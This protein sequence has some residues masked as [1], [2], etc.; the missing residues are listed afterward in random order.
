MILGGPWPPEP[1][2]F[3]L[4][5][6]Q[7]HCVDRRKSLRLAQEVKLRDNDEAMPEAS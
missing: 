7:I 4:L 3:C 6:W 5:W 2:R 1:R